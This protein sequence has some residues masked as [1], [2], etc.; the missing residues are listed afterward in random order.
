MVILW[1]TQTGEAEQRMTGGC[2]FVCSLAFSAD[3]VR[4]ACGT[5][6][7]S[8]HVSD[9]TTGALLCSL[10]S[11]GE[12]DDEGERNDEV[13]WVQFSPV[14]KSIL[15]T[16]SDFMI[17]L[18]DVDSGEKTISFAGTDGFAVFS[19]SG[20]TIATASVDDTSDVHLLGRDGRSAFEAERSPAHR[21][22][23]L[24]LC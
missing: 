12:E 14:K 23:G 5:P 6:A 2:R 13:E 18:W 22:L 3:G 10:Q 16:I 4:L 21:L 1:N 9:A 7:G 19:P 11:L 17:T 15:A 24:L 8:I 20:R